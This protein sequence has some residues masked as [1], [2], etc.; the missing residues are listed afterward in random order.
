MRRDE[1]ELLRQETYRLHATFDTFD[2]TFL[3]P[4]DKAY[5]I[6]DRYGGKVELSS[7][8]ALNLLEW[9]T[10]QRDEIIHYVTGL[11]A[12]ASQHAPQTSQDDLDGR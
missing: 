4:P 9:L 12:K 11:K 6:F 8:E 10:D 5:Y 3:D 7:Q 1:Q 2:A